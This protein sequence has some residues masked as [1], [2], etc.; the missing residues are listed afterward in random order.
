MNSELIKR[1]LGRIHAA[2]STGTLDVATVQDA[3]GQIE[4]HVD[5]EA[6]KRVIVQPDPK[7]V[8]PYGSLTPSTPAPVASNTPASPQ[9]SSGPH[10]ANPV[11]EQVGKPFHPGGT[12]HPTPQDQTVRDRP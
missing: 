8:R 7:T 6:P 5:D 1:Q 4:K 12:A 10:G 2:V 9:P 11:P 3:C